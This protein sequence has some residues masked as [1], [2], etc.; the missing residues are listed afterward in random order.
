MSDYSHIAIIPARKNSKGYPKKNRI[1]YNKTVNFLKSIK[2]F[3]KLILTSDDEWFKPKCKNDNIE[4]YKR[5]KKLSGP[6]VPINKVF[7]DIIK[8]FDF[9]PKTIFWLIYIPL[10]PKKKNYFLL[11]KKQIE[12]KKIKSLCGFTN[13]ITHPYLTWGLKNK[14]IF[15]YVKNDV[16][17]RQ[18]LPKAYSHNHIVCCF[19]INEIKNLNN[20]LL[21]VNTYPLIIK[22]KITEID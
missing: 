1:F 11:A 15:Q 13:V 22:E 16:F 8:N 7:K 18:D 10:I 6:K 17:R 20:E 2:W 21:N 5:D 3:N 19:K 14:K 9:N 12:K 4:F